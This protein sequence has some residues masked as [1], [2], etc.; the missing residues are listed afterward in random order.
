DFSICCLQQRRRL[1]DDCDLFSGWSYFELEIQTESLPQ[2]HDH[3]RPVHALEVLS[4]RSDDVFSNGKIQQQILAIGITQL[5]EFRA[6][7]GMPGS[8]GGAR[9]Y[10]SSDVLNPSRQL[11]RIGLCPPHARHKQ[12]WQEALK[13]WNQTHGKILLLPSR[14]ILRAI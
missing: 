6:T 11:C 1:F 8:D 9:Y 3:A 13:A 12:D 10:A 7:G 4:F 5:L 14:P 2:L